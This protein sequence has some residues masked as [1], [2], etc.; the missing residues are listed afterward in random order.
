MFGIHRLGRFVR[1]AL[2]GLC[3]S[4]AATSCSSPDGL[5]LSISAPQGLKVKSYVVKVQDRSTRKIVFLSGLQRVADGRLLSESPLRVAMPFSQHGKFLV[6]VLAANVDNVEALPQRG[7]SEPLLFFAR[8]VD[9]AALQEIPAQLLAV[10]P[11]LDVDGDHF[12]NAARFLAEVPEAA[13]LYKD[14]PE[15]LDCVDGDP[16]PG[17]LDPLRTRGFDIH[18]FA[19]PQCNVRMR[20]ARQPQDTVPPEL[21]PFD[22]SCAGMPQACQDADG[23]GDPE[24]TDCDDSDPKRFHGNVRPRN[25]CECNSIESCA[26]NHALRKNIAECMPARCDTAVDYDCTGLNVDCFIDEDCDG[27]SPNNPD[28][29]LRDCNDKDARVHPNANK[30]CDPEDGIVLDWACDGRPSAGCTPCDLDGDGFQRQEVILNKDGS[31]L[32]ECPT[33]NYKA[34]G[35]VIDCD[36]TDRGV[37]F[38]SAITQGTATKYGALD[39]NSRGFNVLSA[40][41]GLCR[42]V[43]AN[44][45]VEDSSCDRVKSASAPLRVGCPDPTCDKDQDGFPINTV[46]CNPLGKPSDCN[47]NDST[48]FPGAPTFCDKTKFVDRNCDN[49]ADSCLG[50]DRDGDGFDTSVDCDD[51]SANVH[52]FAPEVCN[53]TDDDCDGLIDEQNPFPPGAVKVGPMKQLAT[54]GSS[55]ILSCADSTVGLCGAKSN[56]LFTGRCVCTSVLPTGTTINQTKNAQCDG[57]DPASK[58][59]FTAYC[60]GANQPQTQSCDGSIDNSVAP[61]E[62]CDGQIDDPTGKNKLVEAGKICGITVGRCKAGKVVGC[63]RS[64]ANAFFTKNPTTFPAKDKFLVCDAATT[65]PID[66][67]CNGFDDNC[68]GQLPV[69][70]QDKDKDRFMAC[71]TCTNWDDPALFNQTNYLYCKDCNDNEVVGAKQFYPSIPALP[72]S[73]DAVFQVDRPGAPELCDGLDNACASGAANTLPGNDGSGMC[74]VAGANLAFPTCCSS[75]MQ[76]INPLTDFKHCGGCGADKACDGTANNA[77]TGGV[78]GC[79]GKPSCVSTSKLKVCNDTAGCVECNNS[80]QCVGSPDGSTCYG[81]TCVK[82]AADGDCA[83]GLHCKVAPGADAG[84]NVALNKANICVECTTNAHCS[85]KAGKNFC[86]PTQNIC[87]P[88]VQK[89]DCNPQD[90]APRNC[91][92]VPNMPLQNSCVECISSADCAKNTGKTACDVARN[93]CVPCLPSDNTCG[94]QQCLVVDPMNSSKNKCV[95]CITQAHCA[96]VAGKPACDTITN[97]CVPCLDASHCTGVAGKPICAVNSNSSLNECAACVDNSACTANATKPICAKGATPKSNACAGCNSK[98]DCAGKEICYVVNAADLSMNICAGCKADTDCTVA[99]KL[100]C[101]DDPVDK[102]FNACTACTADA[103]CPMALPFCEKIAA[104]QSI[105]QCTE[106]KMDA[107]CKV[108][109]RPLCNFNATDPSKTTCV[110]CKVNTDCKTAGLGIC[111][112]VAANPIASACVA[113]KVDT[114]CIVAGKNKCFVDAVVPANTACVQCTVDADCLLAPNKCDTATHKCM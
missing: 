74:G 32:Q 59:G 102:K 114:D 93:V 9:V 99:P 67:L 89:A 17:D 71:S 75:L 36:D 107:D 96:G 34:K 33:K 26:T 7:V 43:D 25:C 18:P 88:C 22:V 31:I 91:L 42:N 106:C 35:I 111:Q 87:V 13:A 57:F 40:M 28:V 76:C 46:A 63:D 68:D 70:E 48:I 98:T 82:C 12:P 49:V 4:I 84:A 11:A 30:I 60:F 110:A 10:P 85:G 24:G 112:V 105:N 69:D 77:C 100:K 66:E 56:G 86:D 73:K 109:A 72:N 79:N 81:N 95:E 61:D 101:Y 64:K 19:L 90:T 5:V 104:N 20:P 50:I 3:L 55:R 37:F 15:V 44:D 41:R 78:C 58:T 52:P 1:L 108:A 8:I 62:D 39:P 2:L 94:G 21:A 6:V 65:A 113:C 45:K 23:D 92:V 27:Y 80:M 103:Q 83:A 53:N 14:Q 47:D 16:P 97:K 38:N 29:R 54:D 51:N